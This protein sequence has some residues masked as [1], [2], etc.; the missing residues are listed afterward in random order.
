MP[1]KRITKG[2]QEYF[3]ASLGSLT[4]EKRSKEREEGRDESI[5]SPSM[6]HFTGKKEDGRNVLKTYLFLR[7][8]KSF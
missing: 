1:G 7:L 6:A 2:R 4:N 5:S 8:T 3:N